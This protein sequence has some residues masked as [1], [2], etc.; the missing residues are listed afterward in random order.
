MSAFTLKREGMFLFY[1]IPVIFIGYPFLHQFVFQSI[2][3]QNIFMIS[4]YILFSTIT[5][6][7][8]YMRVS[9]FVRVT[10]KAINFNNV[11]TI[12]FGSIKGAY[13]GTL[14]DLKSVEQRDNLPI[15][16]FKDEKIA[17]L[18]KV[19]E[20]KGGKYPVGVFLALHV[21]DTV[22]LI[23]ASYF[24]R[25]EM[26]KLIQVVESKSVQVERFETKRM[27]HTKVL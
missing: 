11:A 10:D 15:E 8:M 24:K 17:Y 22:Y 14:E 27:L 1:F 12:P 3:F 6:I 7:M 13:L 16:S 19:K 26:D 18:F 9:Y 21:G 20:S 2:V 23:Q 5:I 25:S 4:L